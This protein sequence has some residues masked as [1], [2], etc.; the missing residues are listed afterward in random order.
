MQ[1]R[2][3]SWGCV[4]D[5]PRLDVRHRGDVGKCAFEHPTVDVWPH[6]LDDLVSDNRQLA[7][8]LVSE[9]AETEQGR[10]MDEMI[11]I[12]QQRNQH[13]QQVEDAIMSLLDQ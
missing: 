2:R 3:Q 1:E 5:G 8:I 7:G 12:V 10:N 6:Q 9:T 11:V 13:R 4:H